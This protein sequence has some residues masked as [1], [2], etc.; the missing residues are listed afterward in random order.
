MSENRDASRKQI[1]KTNT[2]LRI[3]FGWELLGGL[4]TLVTLYPLH[5]FLDQYIQAH[6]EVNQAI[7]RYPDNFLIHSLSYVLLPARLVC[8][9]AIWKWKKW[10]V[11][12]WFLLIPLEIVAI[13][14]LRHTTLHNIAI[15]LAYDLAA[16]F[17]F[18][19][20]W[21]YFD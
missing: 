3:F 13:S 9:W 17:L 12:G 18:R 6:P 15:M 14:S 11:Y 21:Q 8:V 10:G 19:S 4:F 1:R 7:L 5:F 16:F 2:W 20:L